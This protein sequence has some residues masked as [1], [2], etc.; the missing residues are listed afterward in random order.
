MTKTID[1]RHSDGNLT[2]LGGTLILP[3]SATNVVNPVVGGI[4]YNTGTESLELYSSGVWGSVVP[5]VVLG[6]S[7]LPA[8]IANSLAQVSVPG[9]PA[10]SQKLLIIP[11][12]QN[13][14]VPANFG[15]SAGYSINNATLSSVFTVSYIRS[16]SPTS[17]GTFT[18]TS[19][20]STATLSTQAA[21]NLLTGDV[22]LI[23]APAGVDATLANVG[24]TLLLLKR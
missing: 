24:L 2:V 17:I 20:G 21:V 7:D 18:F 12:V 9:Q 19:A 5:S 13:T 15:G 3:T 8:Q 23:V 4:R 16:G 11:I 1:V 14:Q 6:Y 10:A 22:L